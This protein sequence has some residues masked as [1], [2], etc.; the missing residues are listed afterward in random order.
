LKE[1]LSDIHL[2]LACLEILKKNKYGL[3][4]MEIC[5]RLNGVKQIRY[6]H[7]HG[8][9]IYRG[10]GSQKAFGQRGCGFTSKSP[11][12]IQYK[13]VYSAL[14]TL[15]RKHLITSKKARAKD[16]RMIKGKAIIWTDVFRF[17]FAE[18]WTK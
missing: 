8:E 16:L 2:R 14:K 6:C 10:K 13:S 12:K 7:D 5:R 17:W 15:E 18:D 4:G 11:C 9:F 3:N 1:K